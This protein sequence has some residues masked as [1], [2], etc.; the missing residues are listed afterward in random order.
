MNQVIQNVSDTAF[1]VAG[2]RGMETDRPNPLF[3]DPLA[4]KLA[5]EHGRKIVDTV[6]RRFLG[7]WSVVIRTVIIDSFIR[8]AIAEG[9]DTVLNLGAGLDTRPYRMELRKD[10]RWIEVDYPHVIDLKNERLTDETPNCALERVELDLTDRAARQKF[11]AEVNAGAGAILILTEGVTPYLTE[12]DVG[13]LADDLRRMDKLRG[14]IIDYSSPK[15]LKYGR[16]IRA[17]FMQAA[18]F[19]F[20]PKDWFA[21]FEEHGW[22]AQEVRYLGD[23]AEE[24]RRPPLMPLLM[25]GWLKLVGLFMSRE[26]RRDMMR[27]VAY[28]L[29]VPK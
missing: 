14:W 27:Q 18:P 26:R 10:L 3:R 11:F 12:D 24:L 6:P 2:F 20:Q 1:L 15:A 16:K 13:A 9:V 29:L 21:F 7:A 19:L 17:R 8:S 22:H 23:E 28:V 4:W 5:G 25:K